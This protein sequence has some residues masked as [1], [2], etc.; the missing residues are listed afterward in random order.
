MLEEELLMILK[1]NEF[2]RQKDKKSHKEIEN[3]KQRLTTLL[4]KSAELMVCFIELKDSLDFYKK[5][6][7][8][9]D[10]VYL[11]GYN[12]AFEIFEKIFQNVGVKLW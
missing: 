4:I 2:F 1:E 7:Y 5:F 8:S 6:N 9:T 10:K 3:L 11:E 12:K